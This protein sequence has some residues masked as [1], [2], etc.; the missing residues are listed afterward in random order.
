MKRVPG[1]SYGLRIAGGADMERAFEEVDN[2]SDGGNIT[3]FS[4]SD[5]FYAFQGI[6]ITVINEGGLA[7]RNGQ[8][9]VGD[10]ILEVRNVA[11]QCL[12]HIFVCLVDSP[13][14][15]PC[16]SIQPSLSSDCVPLI[17]C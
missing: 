6:Y 12:N 17:F 15:S 3:S 10:K 2:V 11:S 7:D 13:S 9:K 14:F 1:E 5:S 4:M 8:L 16:L